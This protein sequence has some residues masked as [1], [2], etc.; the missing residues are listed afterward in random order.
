MRLTTLFIFFIL[1]NFFSQA[2]QPML[3]QLEQRG[4]IVVQID[5]E[6]LKNIPNV[7]SWSAEFSENGK[8]M[9]YLNKKHYETLVDLAIPFIPATAPGLR[10]E[11][12]MATSLIAM[13]SWDAY[14]DYTTYLSMMEHFA[15]NYPDI[16][17]LDTIG[18]TADDRLLLAVKISDNVN[19]DETEPEFFYTSSMHGDELTGYVLMLRLIDYL[20][21]NYNNDEIKNLVDNT[22]IYINPL[23]NPDGTFAGGNNTVYGATR[24]NSNKVDINRNFPDPVAGEHPDSEEWQPETI[25]MMAYMQKRNFSLSMNFHGGAELLNYPWDHTYSRH[26]DDEWLKFVSREYVDTVHFLDASYMTDMSNGITHGADWYKVYGGRQDYVTYFCSGIEI[27]AEISGVKLV[28]AATLPDYW[29]KSYRS[30]INFIK[31]S[32]FGVHGKVTDA[33]GIPL[34]AKISI[35]NY[36]KDSSHVWTQQGGVFYRYLKEGTYTFRV[37]AAGYKT[38]LIS[39][40]QLADYNKKELDIVLDNDNNIKEN[41]DVSFSVYPNPANEFVTVSFVN[42]TN[43]ARE[44]Q[45]ISTDGKIVSSQMLSEKSSFNFNINS[46]PKGVYFL[47]INFREKHYIKKLV[48]LH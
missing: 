1:L 16:C 34:K 6:Y 17:V 42:N 35:P 47:R 27:T 41:E 12:K 24:S 2:Q 28:D 18:Y 7:G 13:N 44:L 37:E 20:L 29:D 32:N 10:K 45:L 11:V 31:Q 26:P 21:S 25:A 8:A 15:I 39:D 22:E 43:E 3:L 5:A 19:T 9:L 36:D 48:V 23:A 30:L 40:I 33:L 46:Y 4:E 38:K 14:P